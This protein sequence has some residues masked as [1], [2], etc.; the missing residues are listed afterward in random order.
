MKSCGDCRYFHKVKN[1]RF[2]NS[3][4]CDYFD[5][6]TN[7]DSGKNCLVFKKIKYKRIKLNYYNLIKES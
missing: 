1:L 4:I 6:R 3:G 2:G 5:T 7:E